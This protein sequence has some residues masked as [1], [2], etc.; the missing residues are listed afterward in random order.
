MNR[1]YIIIFL[2]IVILATGLFITYSQLKKSNKHI[3]E[4]SEL[5]YG[6]KKLHFALFFERPLYWIVPTTIK[7]ES[8]KE[9]DLKRSIQLGANWIVSMQEE[10]GRY[11]Y[12]F[13]A[14]TKKFSSKYEDNFLR[15]AGTGYSL[16]LVYEVIGDEKYLNSALKNL[17]YL[18]K[19]QQELDSTKKYFLYREK[20]K[21]G[22]V[23]LPMLTML[24]YRELTRDTIFDDDLRKFGNMILYLQSK[25]NTGKFKSTYIYRGD[26]DHE[27]NSGW[28]SQIYPGEAMLALT[29]MYKEFNDKIYLESLE[30]AFDYYSIN[31]NWK[32]NSFIP[33]TTSAFSELYMLTKKEEYAEF[34]F[35]MSDKMLKHQ[36]LNSR[37]VAY[38][39]L[40]SVPS[41]F[42]S[43]WF[44]GIGDAIQVAESIGDSVRYQKYT[45]RSKIAYLWLM[46]L[47]Y[48]KGNNIPKPAI[49]GFKTNLNNQK[50][51][52][53]NTQHAIS[54][55][56]RGMKY[57]Y[58]SDQ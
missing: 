48:D 20:A 21:L 9:D 2:A 11:N 43:T 36:N 3:K 28:E 45:D 44:E 50:I 7:T 40:F 35:R 25:Y 38:G 18:Y 26:Y 27:K 34:V 13:N 42:T 24:K 5:P 54:A 49:G 39:S 16:L 32:H 51:R 58:K 17:E 37:R 47:Q 29:F 8:L 33:W 14:E 52:I 15:Q 31:G 53:D 10:T 57:I 4:W 12:W 19:F 22:G 46:K 30:K 6:I 1:K 23:A 56:C 41:V 55:M